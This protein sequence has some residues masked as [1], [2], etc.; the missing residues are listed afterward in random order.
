MSLFS[1]HGEL[2]HYREF[3][4]QASL[5]PLAPLRTP[6]W[7]RDVLD[8]G[9]VTYAVGASTSIEVPWA[10]NLESS[11]SQMSVPG[12]A[13]PY[14]FWSGNYSN[15]SV[16]HL[17]PGEGYSSKLGQWGLHVRHHFLGMYSSTIPRLEPVVLYLCVVFEISGLS[18]F[19]TSRGL[20]TCR[21]R[22]PDF[23]KIF[24]SCFLS[25]R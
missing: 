24:V 11:R 9:D 23:T 19:G 7:K 20:L 15:N 17:C 13:C 5:T 14:G 4:H 2:Y 25:T 3:R 10:E 22:V 8:G 6:L 18:S 16:K 21:G 12:S 1:V